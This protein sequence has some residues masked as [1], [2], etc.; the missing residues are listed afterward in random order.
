[1]Y[2]HRCWFNDHDRF[3]HFCRLHGALD[4]V[5]SN[6]C[7]TDPSAF[8]SLCQNRFLIRDECTDLSLRKAL[9]MESMGAGAQPKR[10]YSQ[11]SQGAARGQSR[12]AAIAENTMKLLEGSTFEVVVGDY[13]FYKFLLDIDKFY[14]SAVSSK[15]RQIAEWSKVFPISFVGV[16]CP[17]YLAKAAPG[18]TNVEISGSTS[19]SGSKTL[20]VFLEEATDALSCMP[21]YSF[22]RKR[23]IIPQVFPW[24]LEC[25]CCEFRKPNEPYF[26]LIDNVRCPETEKSAKNK[27]R[28]KWWTTLA[29]SEDLDRRAQ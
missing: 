9:F 29:L 13:I 23:K 27:C 2:L 3:L 4:E 17:G 21:V 6:S 15:A 8:S 10:G 26:P 25:M 19:S 18:Y 11:G 1:M 16:G 14:F 28:C 20:A 12:F 5:M 22:L 24:N 7:G